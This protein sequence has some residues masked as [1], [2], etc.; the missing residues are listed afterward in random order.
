MN[1]SARDPE[2]YSGVAARNPAITMA[3]ITVNQMSSA[4]MAEIIAGLTR[5]YQIA[6]ARTR[7]CNL[8]VVSLGLVHSCATTGQTPLLLAQGGADQTR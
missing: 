2:S 6:G 5:R 8:S 1:R 7:S 4:G 3:A